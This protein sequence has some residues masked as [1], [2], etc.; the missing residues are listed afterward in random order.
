MPT[1]NLSAILAEKFIGGQRFDP[2]AISIQAPVDRIIVLGRSARLLAD[3]HMMRWQP[4][5]YPALREAIA[6][7]L[8][9]N[10]PDA[11]LNRG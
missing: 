9:S 8:Q 10:A 4:G 3:I 6:S 7:T 1:A 5:E 11:R 2:R